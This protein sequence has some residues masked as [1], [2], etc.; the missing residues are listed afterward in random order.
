M[1][2][3]HGETTWLATSEIAEEGGKLWE[4]VGSRIAC[5]VVVCVIS[6]MEVPL[7]SVLKVQFDSFVY[8]CI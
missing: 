5:G 2:Q 3:S 1:R 8:M 7:N 6:S 4:K